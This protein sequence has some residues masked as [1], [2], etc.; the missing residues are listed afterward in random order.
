MLGLLNRNS[1]LR[2]QKGRGGGS[3][4]YRG[5]HRHTAAGDRP[6][7]AESPVTDVRYRSASS[8]EGSAMARLA[9]RDAARDAAQWSLLA[10][11]VG[12]VRSLMW[13]C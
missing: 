2:L 12:V 11:V 6:R 10:T 8:A 9:E 4:A 7:A 3:G 1:P 5:A 13:I